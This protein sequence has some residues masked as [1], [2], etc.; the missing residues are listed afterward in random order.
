MKKNIVR[1]LLLLTLPVAVLLGGSWL[2]RYGRNRYLEPMPEG[3]T[4]GQPRIELGKWRQEQPT[5]VD[6]ARGL[7]AR[8]SLKGWA[9]G[10]C[11]ATSPH[12]LVNQSRSP[13]HLKLAYLR[14][15]HWAEIQIHSDNSELE[16]SFE[17]TRKGRELNI[18]LGL[19]LDKVPHNAE[20]VRLRG[21]LDGNMVCQTNSSNVVS[22][23]TRSKNLDIIIKGREAPWP[24]FTGERVSPL[25]LKK[26]TFNLQNDPVS[27]KLGASAFLVVEAA[28]F[29]AN[30]KGTNS[31]TFVRSPRSWIEDEK[32]DFLYSTYSTVS[33]SLLKGVCRLEWQVKK[34]SLHG[35][36]LVLYSWV[37]V[38]PDEWP[39]LVKIP[40]NQNS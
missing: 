2:I 20:E 7:S 5:S 13:E 1:E 35:R 23:R 14:R 11:P 24:V 16:S 9:G 34:K 6:F 38:Q 8:W 15:G 26:V 36:H 31:S 12:M 29:Y 3:I 37:Y 19:P 10:E 30:D 32:E 4:Q 40:L 22:L 33:Y 28:F 25:T 18:S 27:K 17:E 21:Y 39:L